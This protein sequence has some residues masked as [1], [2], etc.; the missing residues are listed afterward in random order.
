MDATIGTSWPAIKRRGPVR[1]SMPG[2]GGRGMRRL[3][4]RHQTSAFCSRPA[5]AWHSGF[6][7]SDDAHSDS[8]T[9]PGLKALS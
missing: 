9:Q 6:K 5:F 2:R 4:A 7:L 8:V 1:V 3:A